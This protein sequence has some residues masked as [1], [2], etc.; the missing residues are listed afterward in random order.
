MLHTVTDS[1]MFPFNL[2]FALAPCHLIITTVLIGLA[3]G[4]TDWF[5]FLGTPACTYWK[6]KKRFDSTIT[7][8]A[9]KLQYLS[10]LT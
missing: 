1:V 6:R 2:S 4:S 10:C 5:S 9:L 8:E 3:I 7:L